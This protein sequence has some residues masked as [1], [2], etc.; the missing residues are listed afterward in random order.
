METK[1][2]TDWEWQGVVNEINTDGTFKVYVKPYKSNKL[3]F[4]KTFYLNVSDIPEDSKTLLYPGVGI[5]VNEIEKNVYKFEF[6][7]NVILAKDYVSNN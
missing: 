3:S 2:K 4:D 5:Y 7:I 1:K 6:I